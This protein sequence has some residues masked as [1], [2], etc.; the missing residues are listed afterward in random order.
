MTP[1]EQEIYELANY[2][3]FKTHPWAGRKYFNFELPL[4]PIERKYMRYARFALEFI[5]TRGVK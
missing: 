1:T 5:N 3:Y 2:I 4:S